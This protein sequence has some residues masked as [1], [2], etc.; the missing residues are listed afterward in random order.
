[1][2]QLVA[3]QC[4]HDARRTSDLSALQLFLQCF[5]SREYHHPHPITNPMP[6]PP[7]HRSTHLSKH[8]SSSVSSTG[9]RWIW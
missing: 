7:F 8:S 5:M 9:R 1:M 4:E 2:F 3:P 6:P